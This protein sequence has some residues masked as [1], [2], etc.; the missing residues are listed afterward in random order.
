M[1]DTE[2]TE[3]NTYADAFHGNASPNGPIPVI[4]VP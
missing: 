4:A 1:T 2:G 3:V